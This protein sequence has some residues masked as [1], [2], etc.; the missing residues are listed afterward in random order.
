MLTRM[1]KRC[2]SVLKN[3]FLGQGLYSI[4][5]TESIDPTTVE[6][7]SNLR[8]NSDRINIVFIVHDPR[9]SDTGFSL[10]EIYIHSMF[11][12]ELLSF[13][14][15]CRNSR[16]MRFECLATKKVVLCL[17]SIG[18]AINV[19]NPLYSGPNGM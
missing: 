15:Q 7:R 19:L 14:L 8:Q 3:S 2:E 5:K 1:Y 10:K 18:R 17:K 6:T 13:D 12:F 9:R 11:C 4:V 16:L